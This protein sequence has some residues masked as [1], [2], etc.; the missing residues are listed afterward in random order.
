MGIGNLDQAKKS[1][2]TASRL[3]TYFETLTLLQI[4]WDMHLKGYEPVSYE[5]DRLIE[6]YPYL[7]GR[8]KK[9]IDAYGLV[10]DESRI[11]LPAIPAT[12]S[13]ND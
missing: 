10:T 6:A 9:L 7:E 2:D 3:G 4:V 5:L 13:A 1:L 8:S 12:E 11:Q